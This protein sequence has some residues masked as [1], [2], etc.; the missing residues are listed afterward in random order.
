MNNEAITRAANKVWLSLKKHSPEILLG[1]GI[2]GGITGA[3]MACRAT[4]KL[5]EVLKDAK[6]EIRSIKHVKSL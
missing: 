6:F 1:F 3:V 2:A 5:D 4:T